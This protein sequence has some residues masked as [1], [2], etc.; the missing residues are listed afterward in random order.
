[1]VKVTTS[2][3][4]KKIQYPMDES[5]QSYHDS[6]VCNKSS[7]SKEIDSFS[8]D[9]GKMANKSIQYIRVESKQTIT[10]SG[11]LFLVPKIDIVLKSFLK[12]QSHTLAPKDDHEYKAVLQEQG[13]KETVF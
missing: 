11:I 13:A 12:F 5:V 8:A 10:A 7:M 2:S 4:E 6:R 9:L 1:M 3:F